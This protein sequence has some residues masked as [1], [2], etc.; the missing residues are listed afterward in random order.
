MHPMGDALDHNAGLIAM[1]R[2]VTLVNLQSFGVGNC[3]T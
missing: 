2:V 1:W 3:A